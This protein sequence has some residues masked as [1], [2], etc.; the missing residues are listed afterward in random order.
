MTRPRRPRPPRTTHPGRSRAR[1]RGASTL[2]FVLLTPLLLAFVGASVQWTLYFFARHV[3][4]TAAQAG[5]AT[6]QREA[7][8]DP[9]HWQADAV[10]AARQRV[11]ALAPN[12]LTSL[13]ITPITAADGTVGVAVHAT[14]PAVLSSWFTPDVDVHAQGPTEAFTPDLAPAP[15][16][17]TGP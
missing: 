6:A 3:A 1:Q 8:A 2:E 13:Q 12:L 9:A 10:S 11:A 4:E 16:S 17:R 14:V 7:A 5:A 15:A